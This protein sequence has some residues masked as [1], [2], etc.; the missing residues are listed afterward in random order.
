MPGGKCPKAGLPSKSGTKNHTNK[1]QTTRSIRPM[2]NPIRVVRSRS[3]QSILVCA[4]EMDFTSRAFVRVVVSSS[5]SLLG[6]PSATIPMPMKK[7]FLFHFKIYKAT[8]PVTKS[9]FQTLN[10]VVV[11]G[12][13]PGLQQTSALPIRLLVRNKIGWGARALVMMPARPCIGQGSRGFGRAR[14]GSGSG[15]PC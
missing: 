5:S 15:C 12:K 11:R 10:R 1:K 7:R 2:S 8:P 13:R 6:N 9:A 14:G 3:F 4:A